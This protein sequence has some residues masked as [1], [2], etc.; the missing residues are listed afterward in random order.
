[1]EARR[2]HP[3][4]FEHLRKRRNRQYVQA[5]RRASS[6]LDAVY[7]STVVVINEG[8][9]AATVNLGIYDARDGT[10]LG[11]YA[12]ASI[13]AG[14]ETLLSISTI[15]TGI[16]VTPDATMYHYN[17]QVEGAFNGF[18]QHLVNNTQVGVIT[19]MS[20][21]CTLTASSGSPSTS[22]DG[23]IAGANSDSGA[24]SVT[25]EQNVAAPA[26]ALRSIAASFKCL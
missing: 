15:E 6:L 21:F 20:V 14:G 10:Q 16:S 18:M 8:V 23:V 2:R 4:Q 17:I 13:P 5:D 3:D 25:V 19:D 26:S 24:L 22:L 1:M 12:T 9:T 11:T 7:P